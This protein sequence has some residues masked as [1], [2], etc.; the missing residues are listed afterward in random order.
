[1]CDYDLL[2]IPDAWACISEIYYP[3]CINAL[4]YLEY[5]NTMT[6]DCTEFEHHQQKPIIWKSTIDDIPY[7]TVN[8]FAFMYENIKNNLVSNIKPKIVL[9]TNEIIMYFQLLSHIADKSECRNMIGWFFIE[10]LWLNDGKYWMGLTNCQNI[11]S[12]TF[13]TKNSRQRIVSKL[14]ITNKEEY[15]NVLNF[16]KIPFGIFSDLKIGINNVF[17]IYRKSTH[18]LYTVNFSKDKIYYFLINPTSAEF[19]L[20]DEDELITVIDKKCKKKIFVPFC[21]MDFNFEDENY[22]EASAKV[23]IL[24]KYK[25]KFG[26][27]SENVY[28]VEKIYN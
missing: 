28:I 1:M 27:I 26:N 8:T 2:F 6:T 4:K 12:N 20:K 3:V 17:Y 14:K 25:Q 19:T 23:N 21:I 10:D 7:C 11:K 5:F 15:H 9:T 24:N 16:L 22:Y 13:F 18:Q